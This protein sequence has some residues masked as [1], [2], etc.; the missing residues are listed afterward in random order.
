VV[1]DPPAA[2]VAFDHCL[3]AQVVLV[4]EEEGGLGAAEAADGELAEAVILDGERAVGHRRGSPAGA[5]LALLKALLVAPYAT[6]ES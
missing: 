5:G 4:G 6:V 1:L 3:G 2:G